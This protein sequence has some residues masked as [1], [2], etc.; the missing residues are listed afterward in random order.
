MPLFTAR[1]FGWVG[2]LASKLRPRQGS[3]AF[4]EGAQ[5]GPKEPIY[6]TGFRLARSGAK[7]AFAPIKKHPLLA[8]GAALAGSESYDFAAG[9]AYYKLYNRPDERRIR[10]LIREERRES[11]QRTI[12]P[13][14]RRTY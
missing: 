7:K 13:R 12:A 11:R 10:S 3:F 8:A 5:F 2:K 9:A 4:R 6:K 1:Q 14:R